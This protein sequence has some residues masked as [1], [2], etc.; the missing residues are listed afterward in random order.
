ML[1]ELLWKEK[2]G[3]ALERKHLQYIIVFS[4]TTSQGPLLSQL[5][6]NLN[7]DENALI[8]SHWML[9]VRHFGA[10]FHCGPIL[11]G[12]DP[13]LWK[14]LFRYLFCYS[15]TSDRHVTSDKLTIWWHY[16]LTFRASYDFLWRLFHIMDTVTPIF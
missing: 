7:L 5:L 16:H 10:V 9:F 14:Y 3:K 8:A 11:A 15:A 13:F 12:K 2:E 1:G 4:K 6:R